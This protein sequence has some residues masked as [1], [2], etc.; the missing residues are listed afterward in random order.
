MHGIIDPFI[1]IVMLEEKLKARVNQEAGQVALRIGVHKENLLPAVG[2]R[3]SQAR[4]HGGLPNTTLM[5]VHRDDLAL[6]EQVF[7]S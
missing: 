6:V 4:G 1:S 3:P 7:R 5:V 2:Q